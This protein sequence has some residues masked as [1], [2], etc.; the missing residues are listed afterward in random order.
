MLESGV[1]M[2]D[3][4][5]GFPRSALDSKVGKPLS[6]VLVKCR[7]AKEKLVEPSHLEKA[8]SLIERLETEIKYLGYDLP[9]NEHGQLKGNVTSTSPRGFGFLVGED[10]ERY[11]FHFSEV[12]NLPHSASPV[13]GDT[14]FFDIGHNDQ[15]K[16]AVNCYLKTSQ[17]APSL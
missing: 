11:W 7:N 15:G 13:E 8:R 14:L 5:D 9:L 3:D 2:L 17:A 10:S 4:L 6:K 1:K 12:R 16:C